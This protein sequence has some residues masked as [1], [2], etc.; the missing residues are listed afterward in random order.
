[1]YVGDF[2][3][4]VAR[5]ASHRGMD[6]VVCGH[7]HKAELRPIGAILY[8]NTGDWVESCTALAE[9]A[10]GSLVLL[11]FAEKGHPVAAP[12]RPDRLVLA[13]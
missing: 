11:T 6:G 2:E 4:S 13:S 10:D 8:C 3:S 5:E 12:H 9:R 7:I 1:M